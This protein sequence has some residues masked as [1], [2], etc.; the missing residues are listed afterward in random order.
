MKKL[1][2]IIT[3]FLLCLADS[4][5]AE[6]AFSQ[7]LSVD[8]E[9]AKIHE[10]K[11]TEVTKLRVEAFQNAPLSVD[12]EFLANKK[13]VNL[14]KVSDNQKFLQRVKI[15]NSKILKYTDMLLA[16]AFISQDFTVPYFRCT[17]DSSICFVE[18][19]F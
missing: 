3:L 7:N 12:I 4:S 15:P 1:L 9:L 16:T 14:Y 5:L 19:T 13:V 8:E 10:P 18:L 11:Y 2:L 6:D 17:K